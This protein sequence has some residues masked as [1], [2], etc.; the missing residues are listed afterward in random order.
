MLLLCSS[1]VAHT[2]W[3]AQTTEKQGLLSPLH[4][5]R[6]SAGHQAG[7]G[8]G[9]ASGPAGWGRADWRV[10]RPGAAAGAQ[11]QIAQRGTSGPP[12]PLPPGW[13]CLSVGSIDCL[14]SACRGVGLSTRHTRINHTHS[15]LGDHS[16]HVR[17]HSHKP[18]AGVPPF[19]LCHIDTGSHRAR[20]KPPPGPRGGFDARGHRGL[21]RRAS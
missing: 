20:K 9:P 10:C 14:R 21:R 1:P 2:C 4:S 19:L 16:Q 6:R 17:D 5:T 18:S 7:A 11:G 15:P 8:A 13:R 3:L 12:R